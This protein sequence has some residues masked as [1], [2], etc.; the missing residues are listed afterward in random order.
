[1]LDRLSAELLEHE[2]LE[3]DEVYRIIEEMT[4]VKV[5]PALPPK[6]SGPGGPTPAREAAAPAPDQS[7]ALGPDLGPQPSPA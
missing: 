7:P 4:G 6:A 2:S 3:G 5:R 1:V